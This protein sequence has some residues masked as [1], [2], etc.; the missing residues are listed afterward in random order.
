MI[1]DIFDFCVRLLYLIAEITGSTY[2]EINVI[3]FV[4]LLPTVIAL[5]FIAIIIQRRKIIQLK[6]KD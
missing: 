3:I 6:N 2:E 5:L 4:F 1:N